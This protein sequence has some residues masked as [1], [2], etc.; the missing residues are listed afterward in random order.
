MPTKVLLIVASLWSACAQAQELPKNLLMKCE[1]KVTSIITGVGQ[2]TQAFS[3]NIRLKDGEISDTDSPWMT[4]KDCR[5]K[6]A[7]ISCESKTVLPTDIP[8][9]SNG[10]ER[11]EIK[12]FLSREIGEYNFFLD[13]FSYE[14]R[15]ATGKQTGGLKMHRSGVCKPV[16][17]PLF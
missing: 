1:G 16:G 12:I 17:G 11:R 13:T 5:L 15:N 8:G 7:T 3:V 14:G 6:N 2:R 10:S 9:V 4:G